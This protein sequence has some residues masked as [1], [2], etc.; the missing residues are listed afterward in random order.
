MYKIGPHVYYWSVVPRLEH[1]SADSN[2]AQSVTYGGADLDDDVN[3]A[4]VGPP[5]A[6]TRSQWKHIDM[7]IHG[8]DEDIAIREGAR[9]RR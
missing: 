3:G 4:D 8:G 5:G 6:N 7:S 1:D 2:E 9:W